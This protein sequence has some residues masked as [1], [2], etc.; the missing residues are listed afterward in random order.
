MC[1]SVVCICLFLFLYVLGDRVGVVGWCMHVKIWV[2]I[3]VFRILR[4]DDAFLCFIALWESLSLNWNLAVWSAPGQKTLRIILSL[5]CQIF[6]ELLQEGFD[7]NSGPHVHMWNTLIQWT[8]SSGPVLV[9]VL[10]TCLLGTSRFISC[11]YF[12]PSPPYSTLS[13]FIPKPDLHRCSAFVA[14]FLLGFVCWDCDCEVLRVLF[15]DLPGFF[16]KRHLFLSYIST[17]IIY[18]S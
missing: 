16:F 2:A 6:P 7:L 10:S 5:L 4:P 1:K 9:F 18:T 11:F 3:S 14:W 12:P 17:K 8:I 15:C 13:C